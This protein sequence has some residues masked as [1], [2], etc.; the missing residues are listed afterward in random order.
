M[1]VEVE[2][3][4]T[5]FERTIKFHHAWFNVERSRHEDFSTFHLQ[6]VDKNLNWFIYPHTSAF[7]KIFFVSFPL[8]KVALFE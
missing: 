6:Q 1:S 3:E 8:I 7:R 4:I 2:E 5:N